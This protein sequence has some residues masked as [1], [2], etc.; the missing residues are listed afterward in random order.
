MESHKCIDLTVNKFKILSPTASDKVRYY[1][2]E[3]IEE[4]FEYLVDSREG[5]ENFNTEFIGAP[6]TGKSNLVWAVA[7]HLGTAKGMDVI[8]AGR[9]SNADRWEVFQFKDGIVYGFENLPEG[10]SVILQLGSLRNSNVLIVDAPI[11]VSD[12]GQLNQGPAAYRWASNTAYHQTR[13]GNRRVIH[14]SSLGASTKKG[15]ERRVINVEEKVMRPFTRDD[16]IKCL[17]DPEL[18][19]QVCKT[20]EIENVSSVTTV[21]LVDSKFYYA[22]IN[23]RWFFNFT[24]AEIED[25]CNKIIGRFAE[26][27]VTT[28]DRHREAVNS[29]LQRYQADGRQVVLFTSSYLANV[30]GRNTSA[31]KKFFDFYP[32]IE[33]H[34]GN[35]APGE[36][37]EAD[38]A[39]HLHHCHDLAAAQRAIMGERAQPSY[40]PMGTTSGKT[41][42]LWPTGKLYNLPAATKDVTCN[43]NLPDDAIKDKDA[44]PNVAQW[45]IPKDKSQPFLDF[46]VLVPADSGKWQLRCIQNTVGKSHSADLEQLMRLVRGLL[47]S[48]YILKSTI[49]IAYIVKDLAKQGGVGVREKTT[50]SISKSTGTRS[51]TENNSQLNYSVDPLHVSY[52]QTGGVP[53]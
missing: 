29:A 26:N 36:I 52:V 14:V 51:S 43:Q 5:I 33:E 7:E 42:E 4:L 35:G 37:F 45:F 17:S 39:V 2:R 34:L 27:S 28:G 8:W 49:I 19:K 44:S 18:K 32:L 20:L 47:D 12:A 50:I 21:D 11:D 1:G 15:E 53:G 9:R 30:I 13:V 38:F 24:V 10:L 31:R 16:Y 41:R 46:F 23:A 40:V 22:G 6:G 48:A 3:G 25:E